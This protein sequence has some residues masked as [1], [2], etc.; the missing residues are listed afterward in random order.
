[1]SIVPLE[2]LYFMPELEISAHIVDFS[3][4]SF[5]NIP[6]QL[7]SRSFYATLYG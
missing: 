3:C 7:T 1:M 4:N 5:E 6:K 2:N